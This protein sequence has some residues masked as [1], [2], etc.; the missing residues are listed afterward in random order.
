MVVAYL[1]A[2]GAPISWNKASFSMEVVWC[3]WK[4]CFE[5]ESVCLA[6]PKLDKLRAQLLR[7]REHKRVP[8]KELES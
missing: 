4:F 8:H 5:T 3:G 2:I 1:T 7:L 6:Q